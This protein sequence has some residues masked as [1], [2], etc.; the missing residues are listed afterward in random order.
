VTIKNHFRKN[1]TGFLMLCIEKLAKA[2]R[3]AI[4]APLYHFGEGIV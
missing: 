3:E 4:V 2:T 1:Q